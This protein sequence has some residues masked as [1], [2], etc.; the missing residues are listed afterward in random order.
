MSPVQ[1]G[2]RPVPADGTKGAPALVAVNGGTA[3]LSRGA[4]DERAELEALR[5]ALIRHL[6]LT[7]SGLSEEDV[8]DIA[9]EALAELIQSRRAGTLIKNPTAFAKQIAWRDARDLR[10][11]RMSRPSGDAPIDLEATADPRVDLVEH[12]AL[13]AE[14]A[15]AIEAAERLTPEQKT[16]YRSRFVEGLKPRESRKALG[17]TRKQYYG[18]LERALASIEEALDPARFEELE[19]ELLRKVIIGTASRAEQRRARR[20][21][22]ADPVASRHVRELLALHRGAAAA[23]PAPFAK[24]AAIPAVLDRISNAIDAMRDRVGRGPSIEQ[25]AT[26]LSGTGAG[27][28]GAAGA[29]GL[30]AQLAGAGTAAKIALGCLAAGAISATC[31]VTGLVPGTSHGHRAGPPARLSALAPSSGAPTGADSL[32]LHK[33]IA[34]AQAAGADSSAARKESS[35]ATRSDSSATGSVSPAVSSSAPAPVQE[36]DPVVSAAPAPPPANAPGGQASSAD[37]ARE[38]G[39]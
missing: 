30:A 34:Q 20:L 38:F 26:Q 25:T 14:L 18:R 16:V 15:R 3:S 2:T 21:M 7:F 33:V 36:F 13:R 8:E 23:L 29:G 37:V 32:L 35:P 12:I 19:R 17:L 6:R 9:Q 27:R 24:P 1:T 10:R 22:D 39:P 28:A 11:G 4:E 31:V 5:R